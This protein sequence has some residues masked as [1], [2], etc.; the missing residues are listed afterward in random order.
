MSPDNEREF[1]G[2]RI[3]KEK[4]E[5]IKEQLSYGEYIQDW[6]EDAIDRKLAEVEEEDDSGNRL[7][8]AAPAD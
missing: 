4:K 5:R 2:A 3:S 6:L 8:A 1:V 7:M